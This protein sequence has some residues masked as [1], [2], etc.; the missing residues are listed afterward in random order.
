MPSIDFSNSTFESNSNSPIFVIESTN[1]T[2]SYDSPELIT[3]ILENQE[4]MAKIIENQSKLIESL[5]KK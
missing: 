2:I 3:K 1:N 4:Q 5:L